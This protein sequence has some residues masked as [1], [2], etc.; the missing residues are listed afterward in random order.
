MTPRS[1]WLKTGS[2]V[3]IDEVM[4][5]LRPFGDTPIIV[6]DFV[7]SRKH[8]WNEACYIPSASDRQAVERV[9][10][11][12]LQLQ[13][14]DLNEGL[15]FREFV[16]FEPLT[17][18]S[19]SHM[20]LTREFRLFVLDGQIILSTPY[21]EEGDYGDKND[22]SPPLELF[23]QVAQ[24]IQSRFFTMDVALKC[25]GTWNIV[26]TGDGQV[27]GL[28]SRADGSAPYLRICSACSPVTG[29]ELT[30]SSRVGPAP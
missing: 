13:G 12:F 21:W 30:G 1:A 4:A 8:E 17:S 14:E 18:H 16:D 22:T 3:S 27:A 11:R 28:P 5:L 10:T 19:R 9:V 29:C 6:K 26:E 15:V 24:K 2:N 20:P 25:D 23:R 7:K